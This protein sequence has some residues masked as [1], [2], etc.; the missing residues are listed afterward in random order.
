MS[1]THILCIASVPS[2][3]SV[4]CIVLYSVHLTTHLQYKCEFLLSLTVFAIIAVFMVSKNE[5]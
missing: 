4:Y 2:M 1:S 3:Y 5:N